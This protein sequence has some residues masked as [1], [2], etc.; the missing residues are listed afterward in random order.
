MRCLPAQLIRFLVRRAPAAMLVAVVAAA[1]I[2][3]SG[4]VKKDE[5]QTAAP[6]AILIDAESDSVL[7]EKNAD[8]LTAPSSLAK[9]MT[10]EVVFNA[11]PTS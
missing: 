3:A 9:L 5:F 8:Q 7:L 1:A 11:P 2:P 6:Y 10:A 4:Q